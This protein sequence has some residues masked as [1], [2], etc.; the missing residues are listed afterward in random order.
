MIEKLKEL[1]IILIN[2]K[3]ITYLI[4]NINNDILELVKGKNTIDII[5]TK[6]WQDLITEKINL[7]IPQLKEKSWHLF[8]K[9]N[10]IND[11]NIYNGLKKYLN[12]QYKSI[13]KYLNMKNYKEFQ[14]ENKDKVIEV[15]LINNALLDNE[16]INA[17]FIVY[18]DYRRL[19]YNLDNKNRVM[20]EQL[21]FNDS[22]NFTTLVAKY[23]KHPR[24]LVNYLLQ[25][26]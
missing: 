13:F 12:K 21:E 2:E 14:L 26:V 5:K 20:I 6:K 18:E 15:T 24:K 9:E 8:L 7:F 22:T 1:Q 10:K 4:T 19:C 17:I 3:I 23:Y 16:Y 25:F 11:Q